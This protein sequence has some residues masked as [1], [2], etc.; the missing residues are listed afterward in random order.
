MNPTI[1]IFMPVSRN[2]FLDKVFHNLE[3]LECKSEYV[4]LLVLVDGDEKLYVD[5]RNRVELSKFGQRLCIPYKN[6]DKLKKFDL[7][8]RRLRISDIH[9]EAKK[10]I[11]DCDYIFGIEDDTLFPNDTLKKL[12]AHYL[13]NPYMGFVEAIELGRWGIPYIGAWKVDNIYDVQ[14]IES[15]P[16]QKGL[17]KIDAGGFYCFL[18]TRDNYMMNYFKPFEI[19]SLGPDVQFGIELRRQ[20]LENYADFDIKCIHKKKE[21]DI[22]FGSSTPRIVTMT[23]IEGRFRQSNR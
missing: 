7:T 20:G 19:N 4:N 2:D 8:N 3:M 18:T 5:V 22:T 6:K 1:T 17:V 11:V 10:Y 13:R 12:L 23:N 21:G 16:D 15:L 9:N 14:K